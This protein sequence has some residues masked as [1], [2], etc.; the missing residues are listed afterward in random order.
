MSEPRLVQG[1]VSK[2]AQQQHLPTHVEDPQ[3]PRLMVIRSHE[4]T[5]AILSSPVQ[6]LNH[7]FPTLGF[8]V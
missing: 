2:A 5:I 8:P 3:G 4:H 1:K 7:M 6:A